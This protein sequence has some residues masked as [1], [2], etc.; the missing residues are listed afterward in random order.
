MDIEWLAFSRKDFSFPA[1]Q[2]FPHRGIQEEVSFLQAAHPQG[3]AYVLGPIT[4]DH[5]MV[6]VADYCERP[7]AE[8]TDCTLNVMMYDID[9]GVAAMFQ[10]QYEGRTLTAAEVTSLTRIDTLLPG[11]TIQDVL[12]QPCGYSMN[13]LLGEAYWTIHV[14]P[15]SHCSYASFETNVT[16]STYTPLLRA[17]L[18][19]FM[20]ARYSV[21]LFADKAGLEG[22]ADM[23]FHSLVA[24]PLPDD[25]PAAAKQY[26]LTAKSRTEFAG[27]YCSV[28]GNYTLADPAEIM[29][30]VTG[31]MA[32]TTPK[33]GTSE[34]GGSS[35][36]G[37]SSPSAPDSGTPGSTIV[38]PVTGSTGDRRVVAALLAAAAHA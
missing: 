9:P 12:F 14:T 2:K 21:T 26:V 28:L 1:E 25:H 23:P 10:E 20:P 30:P 29:D 27:D 38:R 6:F 19:V 36:Q 35:S 18:G 8:S 22:V 34:G 17:V 33:A 5:W 4:G 37:D 15:E 11:S 7:S 16:T 13:G 24:P 32:I 3:S 31:G